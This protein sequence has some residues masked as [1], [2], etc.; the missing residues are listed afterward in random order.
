MEAAR[1][2]QTHSRNVLIITLACLFLGSAS[3]EGKPVRIEEH[4]VGRPL[5]IPYGWKIHSEPHP[6]TPFDLTFAVAQTNADELEAKLLRVSDP[7]S[8]EY[9]QHLSL[10]EVNAFVAPRPESIARI[11]EWLRSKHVDVERDLRPHPASQEFLV[12]RTTVQHAEQILGTKFSRFSH[13]MAGGKK[14]M[15]TSKPYYL[16]KEVAEHIDFVSPAGRFPHPKY[17]A[18]H[19]HQKVVPKTSAAPPKEPHR[20]SH[21][22]RGKPPAEAMQ[23][24]E[25]IDPLRLQHHSRVGPASV[26]AASVAASGPAGQPEASDTI[27]EDG[28]AIDSTV[29]RRTEISWVTPMQVL[30]FYGVDHTEAI[31]PMSDEEAQFTCTTGPTG[32]GVIS[33]LRETADIDGDLHEFLTEYVPSVGSNRPVVYAGEGADTAVTPA[34]RSST[35]EASL[36]I[37][38]IM[39]IGRSVNTLVWGV[40]GHSTDPIT[41]QPNN[42]ANEP[43]L[44]WLIDLSGDPCPPAVI[45]VSYADNEDSVSLSYAIRVNTEFKKGGVRGIT[46]LFASGDD[47]VGGAWIEPCKRFNPSFPASS[48]WVL[49]VGATMA[50]LDETLVDGSSSSLGGGAAFTGS[51][52]P[53]ESAADISSGGFSTYFDRPVYQ[54]ALVEAFLAKSKGGEDGNGADEPDMAASIRNVKGRAYPDV[55]AVGVEVT[56][57]LNGRHQPTTGTSASTPIVAGILSLLNDQR[58]HSKPPKSLLGFVNPVFYA[59]PE[60]FNDIV[61]G[62]NPGCDSDGFW[63]TDSWDPVTGLGSPNFPKLSA[64]VDTLK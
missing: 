28:A 13:E 4:G 25:E 50:T 61:D 12:L 15:R 30:A 43:F 54:Q 26:A 6:T 22:R 36:D 52:R 10:E 48:P 47:G 42:E 49:S 37:D 31:G 56:V 23:L 18:S 8:E 57:E 55:S 16:P 11:T 3:A 58:I 41:T 9:G 21:L 63:A 17:M 62:G 2:A 64:L 32:Q 33:F 7:A 34:G 35:V 59:H 24:S 5:G 19:K 38:Y 39:S 45:S 60:V 44:E 40:A 27:V 51:K 46:F 29:S 1:L 20:G 53:F 14:V